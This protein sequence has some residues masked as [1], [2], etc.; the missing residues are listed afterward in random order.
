MASDVLM[1]LGLWN[2]LKI[3]NFWSKK[4]SMK[5][6]CD[7][8][9]FREWMMC[10]TQSY[11]LEI[12]KVTKTLRKTANNDIKP[13]RGNS[14]SPQQ[15][16]TKMQENI[17]TGF[18]HRF[19]LIIVLRTAV[20]TEFCCGKNSDLS[21]W[22]LIVSRLFI[23]NVW[24]PSL[25]SWVNHCGT[26]AWHT[27]SPDRVIQTSTAALHLLI[28]LFWSSKTCPSTRQLQTSLHHLVG[29]LFQHVHT[30]ASWGI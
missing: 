14:D 24:S 21:V 20:I 1:L 3:R 12:I 30:C 23:Q 29:L 27:P 19:T 8:S 5:K 6:G 22:N 9:P 4:L 10:R 17:W 15:R 16:L 18:L 26:A 7:F 2:V 28:I 11:N 25:R 13:R